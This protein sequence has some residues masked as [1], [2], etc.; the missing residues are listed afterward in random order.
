MINKN[1]EREEA[2][3]VKKDFSIALGDL[4]WMGSLKEH[5]VYHELYEAYKELE[6]GV[7]K[8]YRIEWKIVDIDESHIYVTNLKT[9]SMYHVSVI[10]PAALYVDVY[11]ILEN[12][13]E[14]SPW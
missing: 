4:E 7:K 13:E 1:N 5:P 2:E 6:N 10:Y 12:G 8:D 9:G 14:I 11:R 3:R